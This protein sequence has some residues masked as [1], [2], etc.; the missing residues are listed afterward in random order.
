MCVCENCLKQGLQNL[1]HEG[2]QVCW[3][4]YLFWA[5]KGIP[6][7]DLPISLQKYQVS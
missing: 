7:K 2:I 3:S 5:L 4:Q 6:Q 1:G